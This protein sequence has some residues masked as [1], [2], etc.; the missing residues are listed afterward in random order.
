PSARAKVPSLRFRSI[1]AFNSIIRQSWRRTSSRDPAVARVSTL[2]QAPPSAYLLAPDH[3]SDALQ[4]VPP[5]T[6]KQRAFWAEPD[7]VGLLSPSDGE[8]D[9]RPKDPLQS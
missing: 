2:M 5:Q 8:A 1:S 9:R 3:P 6:P 4:T 7:V